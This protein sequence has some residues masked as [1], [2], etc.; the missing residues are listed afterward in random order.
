[1]TETTELRMSFS[2][3]VLMVLECWNC[4]G[5]LTINFADERQLRAWEPDRALKCGICQSEF[6]EA[7]KGSL[8]RFH[9]WRERAK[10]AKV[11][12]SFKVP[13]LEP[14]PASPETSA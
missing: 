13:K 14:A 2:D 4:G 3:L 11:R 1:M 6:G 12:I 5:E 8:V 7:A 10:I 9:E